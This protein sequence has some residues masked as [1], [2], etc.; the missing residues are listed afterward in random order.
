MRVLLQLSE[1]INTIL[2]KRINYIETKGTMIHKDRG[3]HH[4]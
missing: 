1:Q 2:S 3:T 4:R